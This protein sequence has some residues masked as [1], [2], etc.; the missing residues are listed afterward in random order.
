MR[1]Y[2]PQSLPLKS[3]DWSRLVHL[4]GPANAE[5]ARYDGV[6]QAIPNPLVLLSPLATQEGSS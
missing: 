2:E 1:P 5:L 4:I 3:L 6:L